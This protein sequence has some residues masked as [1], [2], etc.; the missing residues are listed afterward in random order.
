[1]LPSISALK[2]LRLLVYMNA[3]YRGTAYSSGKSVSTYKPAPCQKPGDGHLTKSLTTSF[4]I[5][6]ISFNL[7]SFSLVNS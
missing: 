2:E 1:M 4:N 6:F 7:I 3:S 5:P